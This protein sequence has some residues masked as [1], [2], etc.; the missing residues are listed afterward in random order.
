[1]EKNAKI[2]HN[3]KDI[4]E[5]VNIGT[6]KELKIEDLAYLVKNIVRYK[7]EIQWDTSKPD[8]T[9]RRLLDVGKINNLGWK[10][11]IGLH[12]GIEEVYRIY[13]TQADNKDYFV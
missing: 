2:Y 4:G 13:L 7:G 9:P 8:G 12:K 6:G 1:M 3:A 10:S 5:F 11:N